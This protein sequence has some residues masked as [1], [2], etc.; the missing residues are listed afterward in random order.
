[1]PQHQT[2]ALRFTVGFLQGLLLYALY[3]ALTRGLWPA[4]HF[5]LFEPLLLCALFI[6]ILLTLSIANLR[7]ITLIIWT[8]AATVIVAALSV[9]D[10]WRIYYVP[11]AIS[12]FFPPFMLFSHLFIWLFIAQVL[13]VSGD[14]EQ[15][16]YASY[17]R[18]FDLAWKLFIQIILALVFVGIFW[19]VLW[20]GAGLFKQLNLNF[21]SDL[22]QKSWFAIP[23]T[24]MVF[25]MGLHL[26]DVR[27][28]L[29]RGFRTL[30]LALLSWLLPLLCLLTLAFLIALVFTSFA[31]LWSREDTPLLLCFT[32]FFLILLIN[33]CYQDGRSL[34]LLFR[35]SCSLASLL[36]IPITLLA[37]YALYLDVHQFGWLF[38]YIVLAAELL[39][40]GF[41]ALGYT[42]Y[43]FR[44]QGIER[45]NFISAFVILVVMLSLLT[46]IADPMRLTVKD[47]LHRLHTRQV[48]I[49]QFNF[50]TLR[51]DSGRFGY[52]AL[53]LLEKS[54]N[55]EIRKQAGIYLAKRSRYSGNVTA[56]KTTIHTESGKLPQ[57]FTTQAWEKKDNYYQLP[58]CLRDKTRICDIWVSRFLD[59]PA[60]LILEEENKLSVFLE[61]KPENW[62]YLGYYQIPY[63]CKEALRAMQD[64]QFKLTP[65]SVL[66][67]E[68]TLGQQRVSFYAINKNCP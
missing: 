57:S 32:G 36:L 18:Y 8:V 31:P 29:V 62:D 41:Y 35:S 66:F 54:N 16:F 43:A 17:P 5:L 37:C 11:Q 68:L 65:P 52:Q 58:L 38:K 33:A 19:L 15:R 27:V 67:P 1:M 9:Y 60:V 7:L 4:D 56:A 2:I 47:Q 46:P 26:T 12:D 28:T 64:G 24:C 22:I 34:S 6:P 25:S 3:Q 21:L 42:F 44:L 59:K 23:A 13:V 20:L 14:A 48:T 49:G 61:T 10:A 55:A 63:T 30:I 39:I 40:L 51:W 45:W 53:L 50:E